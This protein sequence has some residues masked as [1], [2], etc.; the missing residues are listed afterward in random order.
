[1]RDPCYDQHQGRKGDKV[2]RKNLHIVTPGHLAP[3][4]LLTRLHHWDLHAELPVQPDVLGDAIRKAAMPCDVL[5]EFAYKGLLADVQLCSA[6]AFSGHPCKPGRAIGEAHRVGLVK[7][8][9][10]I[11]AFPAIQ[12]LTAFGPRPLADIIPSDPWVDGAKNLD[13]L[14][15]NAQTCAHQQG[16]GFMHDIVVVDLRDCTTVHQLVRETQQPREHGGLS[17]EIEWR[18]KV[19]LPRK[20][21]A[22]NLCAR[23]WSRC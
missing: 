20:V 8:A 5:K 10:D 16:C 3:H 6:G 12:G 18:S 1:M 4:P 17:R 21:H 13:R 11:Q 23:M 19:R 9:T 15:I 14:N 7:H 22:S 2:I